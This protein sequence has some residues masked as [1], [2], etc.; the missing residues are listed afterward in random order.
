MCQV[1]GLKYDAAYGVVM[2]DIDCEWECRSV[3]VC[4]IALDC[5]CVLV[6]VRVHDDVFG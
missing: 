1:N 5:E 6:C 4:V 2:C 3:T